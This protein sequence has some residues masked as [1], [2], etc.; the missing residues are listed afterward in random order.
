[1]LGNALR[2]TSALHCLHSARGH[3]IWLY[4]FA[5]RN[6][7]ERVVRPRRCL[8]ELC[9]EC[10][11]TS[12]EIGTDR[13]CRS[14]LKTLLHSSIQVLL[15]GQPL[16]KARLARLSNRLHLMSLVRRLSPLRLLE[17]LAHLP[18]SFLVLV[19]THCQSKMHLSILLLMSTKIS[20]ARQFDL[21]L[22]LLT[23]QLKTQSDLSLF[24]PLLHQQLVLLDALTG[25][26]NGGT[27][28]VLRNKFEYSS[29][30]HKQHY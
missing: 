7:I 27:F 13:E 6:Q 28:A 9:C 5:C 3:W 24:K 15:S 17:S 26:V 30:A 19:E 14:R 21:D 29:K 16:L 1:M 10:L 8:Q 2:H 11:F 23:W 20:P 22:L 25:A 18:A 12:S 4:S